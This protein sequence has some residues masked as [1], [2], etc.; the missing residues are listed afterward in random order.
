MN[1]KNNFYYEDWVQTSL[2]I[3][4]LFLLNLVSEGFKAAYQD[5]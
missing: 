1:N 3:I 5:S 2:F 4:Y